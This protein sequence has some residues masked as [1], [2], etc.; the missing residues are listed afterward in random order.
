MKPFY[1]SI[2]ACLWVIRLASDQIGLILNQAR[3]V[4]WHGRKG[5]GN[6]IRRSPSPVQMDFLHSSYTNKSLEHL[7]PSL[8]RKKIL[9]S[10]RF[11]RIPRQSI[12]IICSSQAGCIS[13]TDT[14]QQRRQAEIM[15]SCFSK[16]QSSGVDSLPPCRR[17]KDDAV[18]ATF[19]AY[20]ADDAALRRR[21][22]N[23]MVKNPPRKKRCAKATRLA[24][25]T[26]YTE[27]E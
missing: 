8:H 18:L 23:A 12:A 26:E 6:C 15:G 27:T 20:Q 19:A 2:R 9:L 11:V 5:S 7:P 16:S 3:R 13:F 17:A 25:I 1:S 14:R 21:V 10:S 22:S 24:R 4:I